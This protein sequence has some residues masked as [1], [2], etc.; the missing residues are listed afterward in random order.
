METVSGFSQ[1]SVVSCANVCLPLQVGQCVCL[2]GYGGDDCS[3]LLLCEELGRPCEHGN[4]TLHRKN[5][6]P[7]CVCEEGYHG[8]QCDQGDQPTGRYG[9]WFH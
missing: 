4:C 5:G 2:P 1:M 3:Q 7:M 6:R 8:P 9:V